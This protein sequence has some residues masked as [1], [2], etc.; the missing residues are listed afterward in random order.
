MTAVPA[1]GSLR[2]VLNG[3]PL[4]PGAGAETAVEREPVGWVVVS[5]PSLA[6]VTPL[7]TDPPASSAGTPRMIRDRPSA[8]GV[9]CEY[10]NAIA[11]SCLR[12]SRVASSAKLENPLRVLYTHVHG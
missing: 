7:A 12:E 10:N 2:R 8:P 11:P 4:L 3:M 9:R 5:K 6:I 1:A